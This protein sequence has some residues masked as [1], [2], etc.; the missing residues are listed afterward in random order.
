MYFMSSFSNR[1]NEATVTTDQYRTY[2]KYSDRRGVW[3]ESV[4]FFTHPV[5]TSSPQLIK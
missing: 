3:S 4:L 2:P 1:A 5:D